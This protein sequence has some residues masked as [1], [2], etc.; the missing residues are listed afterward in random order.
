MKLSK[1]CYIKNWSKVQT[2]NIRK[3]FSFKNQLHEQQAYTFVQFSDKAK[4]WHF[5][6]LI[7]VNIFV[8]HPHDLNTVY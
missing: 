1:F 7:I 8:A 6:I 4:N 2:V 5:G 3:R